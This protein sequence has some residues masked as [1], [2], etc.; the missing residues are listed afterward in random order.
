M[1]GNVLYMSKRKSGRGSR[2]AKPTPT[3]DSTAGIVEARKLLEELRQEDAEIALWGALQKALMAAGAAPRDIMPLIMGRHLDGVD[4]LLARL[5][6]DA[7]PEDP[8]P[9]CIQPDIPATTLRAAMKAFRRRLKL[10]K[11]DHESRLG[12]GPL[13]GG[14]EAAFDSI[15]PPHEFSDEIWKAL[16]EDG[17]LVSTGRGFY[18][19]PE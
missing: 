10:T 12:V 13:T 14:K 19:L 4:T 9:E 8:E 7:P 1:R 16:A 3:L 5:S 11:L 15:L 6:G 2:H 18:K 17:Q